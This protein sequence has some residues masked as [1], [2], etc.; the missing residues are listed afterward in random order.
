LYF[1]VQQVL[2]E[3]IDDFIENTSRSACVLARHRASDV[4]SSGDVLLHL[5][6]C[7][8]S[9]PGLRDSHVC[10]RLQRQILLHALS[11]FLQTGTG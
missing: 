1:I 4:L 9:Q 10:H 6:R 2:L 7:P 5:G 11:L 3:I 8:V